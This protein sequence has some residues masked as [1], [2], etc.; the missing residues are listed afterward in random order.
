[1]A[2]KNYTNLNGKMVTAPEAQLVSNSAF[3]QGVGLVETMLVRN[4]TIRLASYHWERA[5]AGLHALGFEVPEDVTPAMLEREVLRTVARN[6]LSRLARVRLQLYDAG[7]G[8]YA[9]E[10][11]PPQYIINCYELPVEFKTLNETGLVTGTAAGL[12]KSPDTLANHKTSNALIY[13]M[14]ARQASAN[15]WGDAL[16]AN[17]SGH[18]IEST[19]ANIFWV[20]DGQIHTPPLTEGCVGGVMRRHILASVPAITQRPLTETELAHADEIFLTNAIRGVRWIGKHGSNSYTCR[21]AH[22]LFTSLL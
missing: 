19:I 15:G 2:L 14:A 21:V 20:K 13:A 10:L 3:R 17:T 7:G 12:A 4:G 6:D 16:I 8:V 11:Q 5:F 18:I 22:E 1:M 9:R